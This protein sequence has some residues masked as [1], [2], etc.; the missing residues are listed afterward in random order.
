MEYLLVMP[1]SSEWKTGT[2]GNSVIEADGFG[3]PDWD[4]SMAGPVLTKKALSF[5]KRHSENN[6]ERQN[7]SS[8]II[9]AS[10]V[11]FLIPLLMN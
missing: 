5:L 11:M 3:S 7:H 2:Y 9:G 8:C 6:K 4:S 10:L 1:H